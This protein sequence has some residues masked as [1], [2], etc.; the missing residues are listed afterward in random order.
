MSSSKK[1][2]DSKKN[3]KIDEQIRDLDA[4]FAHGWLV[5]SLHGKEGARPAGTPP[6]RKA[7]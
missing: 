4:W 7:P 2:S 6:D 1:S 3:S 5:R